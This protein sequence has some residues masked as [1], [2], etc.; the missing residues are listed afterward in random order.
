MN[1]PFKRVVTDIKNY[2]FIRK[3][4]KKNIGTIEWEKFKLRVDWIGRI[5]TVVN[6]PP[7]VIYSPDAPEEIRPA[8]ILEESR[9]LN[10][11]L[12]KLN[13]QEIIIPKIE[14]IPN[15]VSYLLTYSPY[16][17]RLSFRWVLY[18]ILLIIVMLWLQYKFG[19]V[20][21]LLEGIKYILFDVIF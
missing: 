9:P 19:F 12:T 8:Y 3:T 15:S 17:Q 5:Y 10:E 4:I 6:L 16:F 21:W 20:S 13:L 7:E 18:R 14:P 2:F 1:Y 11:Y